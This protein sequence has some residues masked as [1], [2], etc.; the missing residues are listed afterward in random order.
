MHPTSLTYYMLRIL[1]KCVP[2]YAPDDNSQTL[3]ELWD[4]FCSS[5]TSSRKRK[6]KQNVNHI[7]KESECDIKLQ[8]G[9]EVV[10][11]SLLLSVLKSTRI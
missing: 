11:F 9:E 1:H 8:C 4:W 6:G 5:Q 3:P 2:L 7:L 10:R